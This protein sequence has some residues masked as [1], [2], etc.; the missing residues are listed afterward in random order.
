MSTFE[1]LYFQP[2]LLTDVFQSMAASIAGYDKSALRTTGVASYPFVSR[3]K[4]EN[5]ID[6]FCSRQK[7]DPEPGNAIA[8][9]LDTQT[10]GFR[11]VA[12]CTSQNIQVLRHPN[13]TPS[14]AAVLMTV[15]KT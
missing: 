2:M 15:I 13:L 14:S 8:I 12:F 11:P 7:K 1:A 6:G 10:V 3:T 9:G 4:A 5:G